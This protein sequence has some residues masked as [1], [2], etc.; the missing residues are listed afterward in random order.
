GHARLNAI[1]R[2]GER[3]HVAVTHDDSVRNEIADDG[4]DEEGV[5]AGVAMN[6]RRE[7]RAERGTA[8]FERNVLGDFGGRERVQWNRF[9]EAVNREIVLKTDR[10][11]TVRHGRRTKRSEHERA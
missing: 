3:P 10:W 11:S 9:G 2:Y 1:D 4:G 8:E 5:A 6:G 7:F